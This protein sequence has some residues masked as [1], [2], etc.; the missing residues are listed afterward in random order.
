MLREKPYFDSVVKL[1]GSKSPYASASMAASLQ[2]STA[3]NFIGF[4][5]T[6]KDRGERDADGYVLADQLRQQ[7]DA[8]LRDNVAGAELLVV[9]ETGQPTAGDADR[10]RVAGSG[11]RSAAAAVHRGRGAAATNRG[12]PTCATTSAP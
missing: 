1:V 9:P 12:T 6:F 10:D 2:P 4:S 11:F 7:I 8:Y 5:A 3:E